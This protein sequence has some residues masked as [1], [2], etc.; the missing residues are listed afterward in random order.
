MYDLSFIIPLDGRINYTRFW[1][2]NNL[3]NDCYYIFADGSH[4]ENTF[5]FFKTVTNNNVI[6]LRFPKDLSHRDQIKKIADASRDLK[7]KYVMTCDND[8]FINYEGVFKC[9]KF[10]EKNDDY[11]LASGSTL[12]LRQKEL[13][14]NSLFQYNLSYSY[15][16][17]RNLDKLNGIEAIEKY[18]D[19]KIDNSSYVWYSVYRSKTFIKV[20]SSLYKINI[21]EGR[22]NEILQTCLSFCYGKYKYINCNHYIRLTNPSSNYNSTLIDPLIVKLI[23]DENTKKDFLKLIDLISKILKLEKDFV[24]NI[25]KK[26]LITPKPQKLHLNSLLKTILSISLY[27]L[28]RVIN[29]KTYSLNSIIQIVNIYFKIRNIINKVLF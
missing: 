17:G 29:L 3:R 19:K 27:N 7:T 5:D 6:Y 8:D 24:Y 21:T 28:N 20:W 2:K 22:I 23:F 18:L 4:D 9:V 10:L 25:V 14:N 15:H 1:L 12:F 26:I 16:S 13:G 11:D